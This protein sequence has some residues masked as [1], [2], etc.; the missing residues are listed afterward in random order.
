[1]CLQRL[2]WLSY[3]NESDFIC[4]FE[5]YCMFFKGV[6]W[7]WNLD[8]RG[9]GWGGRTK[10]NFQARYR[11]PW[12]PP[13][14]TP[15]IFTMH[16]SIYRQLFWLTCITHVS[17]RSLSSIRCF[18]YMQVNGN[19]ILLGEEIGRYLNFCRINI[20]IVAMSNSRI[21]IRFLV[22]SNECKLAKNS[23]LGILQRAFSDLT[24][25]VK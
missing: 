16:V 1:M 14:N 13:C 24:V 19:T 6:S 11:S 20:C 10:K 21:S 7:G 18:L 4:Y 5:R 12:P 9:G 17:Y 3:H 25:L 15:L 2:S 23:I 8:S 22:K